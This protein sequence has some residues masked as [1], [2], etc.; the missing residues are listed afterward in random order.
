MAHYLLWL[1]A[2]VVFLGMEALGV[3]G[4][5]LRVMTPAKMLVALA[6]QFFR[7]SVLERHDASCGRRQSIAPRALG[8]GLFNGRFCLGENRSSVTDKDGVELIL[9]EAAQSRLCFRGVCVF[10]RGE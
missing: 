2:G 1:I 10:L 6:V 3:T 7:Q 5:G 9:Q 4:V 8:D